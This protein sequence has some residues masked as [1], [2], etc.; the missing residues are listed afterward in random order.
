MA[1]PVRANP[2][3]RCTVMVDML[4]DAFVAF[5]RMNVVMRR[6]LCVGVPGRDTFDD[7]L[8]CDDSLS[9]D[10]RFM[11]PPVRHAARTHDE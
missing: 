10:E 2:D 11:M 7:L 4:D 8:G 1:V 5:L 6:E 9:N 3:G